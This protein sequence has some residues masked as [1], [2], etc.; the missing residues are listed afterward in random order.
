MNFFL[1]SFPL[2]FREKIKSVLLK[3]FKLYH[4][5]YQIHELQSTTEKITKSDKL[6]DQKLQQR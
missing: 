5:Y 2:L 4:F 3:T 6:G 1:I